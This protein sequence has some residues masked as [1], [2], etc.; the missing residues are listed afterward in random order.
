MKTATKNSPLDSDW[1]RNGAFQQINHNF[2]AGLV[3][4]GAAVNRAR[5]WTN[6]GPQRSIA[7]NKPRL[8]LAVPDNNATG[9]T[10]EFSTGATLRVE[11]VTVTVDISH[12]A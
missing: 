3:N 4:A 1:I 5:V 11:H 12:K 9:V 10:S 8:N 2:G 7:L 6:L